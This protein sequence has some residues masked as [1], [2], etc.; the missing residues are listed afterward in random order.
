MTMKYVTTTI[1]FQ[2][3]ATM[4]KIGAHGVAVHASSGGTLAEGTDDF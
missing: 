3:R 4:S 2:C 1:L